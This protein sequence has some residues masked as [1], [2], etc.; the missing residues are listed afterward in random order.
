MFW[1]CISG[2]YGKGAG[3]FW[4]KAWKTITKE[5]YCAYTVPVVLGYMLQY[6]GLQFQ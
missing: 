2:K 5:T 6:P 1:G 4:E 3:M